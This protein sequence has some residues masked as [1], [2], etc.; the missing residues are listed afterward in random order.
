M[1]ASTTGLEREGPRHISELSRE[2]QTRLHVGGD[3]IRRSYVPVP[4]NGHQGAKWHLF[5]D[6][7]LN[8]VE[9]CAV[10][11]GII[12]LRVTGERSDS[13]LLQQ[14]IAT[15]CRLQQKN[16]GWTSWVT[17]PEEVET[18]STEEPLTLD[19]FY[20]LRALSLTELITSQNFWDG[21][22]WLRRT[23]CSEGGWGFYAEGKPFVLPTSYAIRILS[24]AYST[25]PN[26]LLRD[27]IHRGLEWMVKAQNH[28]QGWGRAPGEESSSVH[29]ALALMALMEAG[30]TRVSSEVVS[31][32]DWLLDNSGDRSAIFDS[33]EVPQRGEKGVITEARINHL[34][35][36]EG[37]IV[38]GLLAA[39]TDL[40]DPRLLGVVGALLNLQDKDGYW[41]CIHAAFKQP[42]YAIM[43]ACLALQAFVRQVEDRRI[44]LELSEHIQTLRIHLGTLAD[45][46]REVD[47]RIDGL[48]SSMARMLSEMANAGTS[49]QQAESRLATLER[50]QQKLDRMTQGL[51]LLSPVTAISR[52]CYQYRLF[53]CLLLLLTACGAGTLVAW[54]FFG[55]KSRTFF[56]ASFA[57]NGVL[58]AINILT[59]FYQ[60]YPRLRSKG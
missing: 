52:F 4:F 23:S 32:R 17:R 39:E 15:L 8:I 48:D 44:F 43:D 58:L 50:L 59:F 12:I 40:L 7:E 18:S 29:T 41:K 13:P 38:Q 46:S 1:P 53:S 26:V 37:L 6:H 22:E 60:L 28:T 2:A 30:L 49:L 24:K 11:G 56:A 33:Y 5:L 54:Y 21:I 35:F 42:I 25:R 3:L 57:T 45:R 27:V 31:G 20:A 19:T 36:P 47:A 16:G 9:L 55:V 34:N 51:W 14:A 10:A